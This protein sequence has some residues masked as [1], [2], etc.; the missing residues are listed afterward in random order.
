MTGPIEEVATSLR[1]IQLAA[2]TRPELGPDD[3]PT[4]ELVQFDLKA[5]AYSSI[6][7]VRD[8]L[9]GFLVLVAAQNVSAVDLVVRGLYEWTMQASYVDQQNR[10]P[11]K[12]GNFVECRTVM[13]RVQSG[14]GW[15]KRH[16]D[17]YWKPPFEDDIPDSLRIKHLVKAYK[18]HQLERRNEENVEDDYGYLSEHA[19]PNSVC[20]LDVTQRSGRVLEF[21]EP[22]PGCGSRGIVTATILDWSLCIHNI[23]GLAEERVVRREFVGMLKRVVNRHEGTRP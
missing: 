8:L 11:I 9:N 7:Y 19:H 16:G 23:L 13:D 3:P 10:I 17:K 14:N 2:L 1:K 6:A 5:Y 18:A 22:T 15:V 21:V 20:F 4:L 12:S